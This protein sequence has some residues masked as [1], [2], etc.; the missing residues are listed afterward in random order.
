M[1]TAAKINKIGRG[2]SFCA[3]F[4]LEVLFVV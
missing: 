3:V 2:S 4:L 1:F